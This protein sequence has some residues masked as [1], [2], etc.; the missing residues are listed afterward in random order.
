[1]QNWMLQ[2]N[3]SHKRTEF[4]ETL[5]NLVLKHNYFEFNGQLY[6]QQQGTAM[7]T[8][9]A[10]NYAII[11]MH[12]IETELLQKI[13]LKLSFFKRF[14]DDIFLIWPHGEDTLQDF[15]TMVNNYCNTIVKFT[16]EHSQHEIPFLDTLV[17]KENGKLLARVYHKKY[18]KQHLHYRSSH[19]KNLKDAVPYGLLIRAMRISSKDK[20]FKE[21]ATSIITSLLQRGYPD[22]I[23][24]KLLI[25]PG[26]KHKNY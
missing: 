12:K 17:Y 9:I 22:N 10:P 6:L 11:F 4:I 25:E 16:E 24:Q 13:P 14:I 8:R 19:P 20:D 26:Q 2:N 15:L 3:I 1:M 7:G 21:E 5:G 18:Q 23:L